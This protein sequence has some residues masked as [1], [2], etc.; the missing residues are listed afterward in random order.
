[1]ADDP[2]D[3]ELIAFAELSLGEFGRGLGRQG[4]LEEAVLENRELWRALYLAAVEMDD[5]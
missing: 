1:M 5:E 4:V 2:T 3:G